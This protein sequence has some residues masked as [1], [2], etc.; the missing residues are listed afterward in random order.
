MPA[1]PQEDS[2]WLGPVAACKES[3][4]GDDYQAEVSAFAK[5][6]IDRGHILQTSPKGHPELE[7]VG[8]EY[9]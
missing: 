7:G 6:V 2:S 1:V 9:V 3:R 8:I 5:L 4:V